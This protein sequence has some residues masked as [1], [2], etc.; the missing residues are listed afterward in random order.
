MDTHVRT[1]QDGFLQPQRLMVPLFQRPYV[2]NQEN[3]WEPLWD[4]VTRVAAKR[5]GRPDGKPQPHFIGAVV[6]QQ[7][8]SPV[9]LMQQRTIIDG[10]QRL[11][12]LQLL[13]DALHAELLAVEAIPQAKRIEA[14]VTNPEPFCTSPE[15]RFKVWPT[16]RDR[17]AFNAVMAASPPVDHDAVGHRGERMVEAHRFFSVQA[18]QW[19]AGNGDQ[20]ARA[21]AIETAA[22]ELLQMVVIDLAPDEN[23]QEIFETLNARG[24]QLTAADLIKN[25][26]FQRLLEAG[27]DVE[28]AYQRTWAEFET[29]FWETEISV[30]RIRHPRSSIFLNHWLVARTGEEVVAR[31]VFK[32]FKTFALDSGV[33][34]PALLQQVQR[35]AGVYRGFVTGASTLTGAVDRLSLFGLPNRRPRER[36]DQAAGARPARP[37]EG[38][39][40]R[41]AT[42]Q[43]ARCRRELDGSEDARPSDDEV[44]QS[45]RGRAHQRAARARPQQDGR[46]HPGVPRKSDERQSVLA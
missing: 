23:A 34:M 42:D 19:L 38:A 5:L 41:R 17:G 7:L 16:N 20:N 39:Y 26:V 14:L 13:L 24:A 9:G 10:Q 18:R 6:L 21:T 31:E 1:P 22:R 40:P 8:Q 11:T 45:G 4:D 25:F 36:S 15:D 30:G 29:G 43:G 32:R 33:P 44:V 12:T 35:A 37:R 46:H 28:A 3:Q 27:A 2:W